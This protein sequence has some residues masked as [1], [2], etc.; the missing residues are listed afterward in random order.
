MT[1]V[2]EQTF[3]PAIPLVERG[4]GGA[5]LHRPSIRRP[6]VQARAFFHGLEVLL[7]ELPG[8]EQYNIMCD[9]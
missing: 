1:E 3:D 6:G 9:M 8:L 2:T 7:P 4:V 5:N